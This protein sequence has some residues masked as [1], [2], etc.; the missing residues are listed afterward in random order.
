VAV[1]GG[2]VTGCKDGAL[3][4]AVMRLGFVRD[5]QGLALALGPMA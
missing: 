2:G 3:M 4:C 5:P 1:I